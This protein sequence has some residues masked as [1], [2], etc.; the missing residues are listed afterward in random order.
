[1]H[2]L[3][4][5][6]IRLKR[7]RAGLDRSAGENGENQRQLAAKVGK[8]TWQQIMNSF[9]TFCLALLASLAKVEAQKISERTKA[10][11]GKPRLI[12]S[13][14]KRWLQEAAEVGAHA[15]GKDLGSR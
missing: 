6:S 9:E 8:F 7:N 4:Q 14:A 2:R 13:Y 5:S 15:A 12:L 10:G 11:T 1:L 3:S